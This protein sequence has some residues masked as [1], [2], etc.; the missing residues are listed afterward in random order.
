M[1]QLERLMSSHFVEDVRVR[2]RMVHSVL[3]QTATQDE[4]VDLK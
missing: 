3:A 2:A 4:E 1:E